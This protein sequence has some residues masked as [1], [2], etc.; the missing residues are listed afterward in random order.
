MWRCGGGEGGC[1]LKVVG[2]REGEREGMEGGRERRRRREEAGGREGGEHTGWQAD[3]G[4]ARSGC[5]SLHRPASPCTPAASQQLCVKH[6]PP[7]HLH[8]VA[9]DWVCHSDE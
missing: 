2:G 8:N 9:H 5:A 3:M 6:N 1:R 4:E 7:T